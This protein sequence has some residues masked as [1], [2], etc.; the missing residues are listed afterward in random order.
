M[1]GYKMKKVLL[2]AILCS[3]VLVG[4]AGAAEPIH[5]KFGIH[6]PIQANVMQGAYIPWIKNMNRYAPDDM[7][8]DIYPGA[9]L[10]RDPRTYLKLLKDGVQDITF[11]HASFNP[12]LMPDDDVFGM[13]FIAENGEESSLAAWNMYIRG[14]L[15]GYDGLKV[16]S[17]GTTDV[18]RI[19]TNYPVKTPEDLRGK[20]FR[21]SGKLQ[22]DFFKSLGA[23]PV[24]MPI[25]QCAE[26][27]TRGVID[28]VLC[29]TNALYV[30]RINEVAH[31]YLK[32]P[33][34]GC[35]AFCIAMTEKKFNSLPRRA[36][37]AIEMYRGRPLVY[38]LANVMWGESDKCIA[39]AEK[40]P[41]YTVYT[42]TPA[43]TEQWKQALQPVSENWKKEYPRG[44]MLIRE[45]QKELDWVRAGGFG[46]AQ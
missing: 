1:E 4:T 12:G 41:K 3:F 14:L 9:V 32:S 36:Q 30:F 15:T 45:F 35:S 13:P 2:L 20:K 10:G 24:S 42:P 37:V 11:I 27:M 34:M 6:D 23:I 7:V 16:L 19:H 31:Y 18:Y 29:D 25:Q 44:E 17:K 43:E 33:P 8:I 21:V 40:D 38:P 26:N 5:L 46:I 28:G 22:V 39:T